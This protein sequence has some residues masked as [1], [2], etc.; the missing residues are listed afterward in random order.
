MASF[1]MR[2]HLVETKEFAAAHTG[3]LISEALEVLNFSYERFVA[4]ATVDILSCCPL[5]VK[6]IIHIKTITVRL[7]KLNN[8]I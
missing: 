6:V 3:E 8:I 7:E 1:E 5:Y 4:A 2:S